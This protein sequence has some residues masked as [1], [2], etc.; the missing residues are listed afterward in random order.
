[1]NRISYWQ[2]MGQEEYNALL[3]EIWDCIGRATM[4]A[5]PK[6]VRKLD[7]FDKWSLSQGGFPHS[8]LIQPEYALK[9]D[10]IALLMRRDLGSLQ[11]SAAPWLWVRR[12]HEWLSPE[13][14]PSAKP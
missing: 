11:S 2:E 12:D 7:E 1:M 13:V 14:R 3:P 6:I 8:S 9:I 4:V 5:S 10:E